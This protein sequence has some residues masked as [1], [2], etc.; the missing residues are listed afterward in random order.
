MHT[1][2]YTCG[3]QDKHVILIIMDIKVQKVLHY[4]VM[5]LFKK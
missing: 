5:Y 4:K 1:K 2:K 3:L